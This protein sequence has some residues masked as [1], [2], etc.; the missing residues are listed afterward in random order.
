VENVAGRQE[1]GKDRLKKERGSWDGE[2]YAPLAKLPNVTCLIPIS[3][4]VRHGAG[5]KRKFFILALSARLERS[6]HST[7]LTRPA[8]RGIAT[9]VVI[10]DVFVL[11][12][13]RFCL[14]FV[15]RLP[16]EWLAKDFQGAVIVKSV[17]S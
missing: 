3:S 4:I 5:D 1:V 7:L 8:A 9:A 16:A 10:P 13:T 12:P 17:T 15:A 6:R 14:V 2:P 11:F